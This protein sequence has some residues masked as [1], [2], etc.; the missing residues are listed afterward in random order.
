MTPAL[1]LEVL[2]QT[3][4][5]TL[6]GEHVTLV[7][8]ALEHADS[9]FRALNSDEELWRYIPVKQPGTVDEMRG[10]VATALQEQAEGRR[11]PFAVIEKKSGQVIGSTSFVTMSYANRNTDVGWT[12]YNRDFWRTAVNTE[13]KFLLLR[14][15]FETLACIRVQLRVDLRNLRSQRAVERIGGVKDGVLRKVQLLYDGHQRNV[16]IYS[17]LD[18]E[19]PANKAR[20]EAMMRR[21]ET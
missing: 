19:W 9:L 13:C 17:L 15:A 6:E 18:D 12:W 10:W 16:V 11:L 5:V 3:P 14:Y 8:L 2:Y 4:P 1:D 21:D 7:P 20:L